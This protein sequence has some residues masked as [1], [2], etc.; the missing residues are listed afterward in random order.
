MEMPAIHTLSEVVV[1]ISAATNTGAKVI[2]KNISLQRNPDSAKIK[3][4][5][6]A[7]R[8]SHVSFDFFVHYHCDVFMSITG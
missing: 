8:I 2:E 5:P 4:S 6:K 3:Q 1:F 7:L